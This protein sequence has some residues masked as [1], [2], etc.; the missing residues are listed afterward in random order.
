M[1]KK[2]ESLSNINLLLI[3]LLFLS[4]CGGEHQTP[5]FE[6]MP[7]M[8][9]TKMVKAQEEK[10]RQPVPG[11]IP[12]GFSPYAYKLGEGP[13]A[14]RELHNPLP[15]SRETYLAGRN[16]FNTYCAV[17]HGK[18][19][20]GNGSIVPKFPQPPSLVS[21]K[22]VDWKDGEIFHTITLGQNLMPAYASQITKEERWAIAHYVRALQRAAHP[23]EKDVELLKRELEELKQR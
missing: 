19:G 23:T 1:Q 5:T 12:Q 4:S 15:K 22:I 8:M 13:A 2:F 17:C 18:E 16:A 11:T 3:A 10:M 21:E 6:Y 7:D 9:D 14:G 20:L